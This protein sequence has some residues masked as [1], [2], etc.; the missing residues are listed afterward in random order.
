VNN[1]WSPFAV[2]SPINPQQ[3]ADDDR[4]VLRQPGLADFLH[5]LIER[6]SAQLVA[7]APTDSVGLLNWR[8][9][10]LAILI[11]MTRLAQTEPQGDT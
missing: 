9:G 10:R 5:R 2:P 6:E 7:Q 8:A 11:E 3:R 1:R 4:R